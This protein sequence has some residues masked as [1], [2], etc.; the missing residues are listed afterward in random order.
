MRMSL[1]AGQPSRRDLFKSGALL[2]GV[3]LLGAPGSAAAAVRPPATVR[4]RLWL[5]GHAAGSHNGEYGL[6][7]ASQITP[8]EAAYY[9]SIPNM[10]LVRYKGKPEAPFDQYAIPFRSL[11]EVVWSVVGAGGATEAAERE[12]VLRM[13][14][15]SPNFTGVD[16]DD[17]F[18]GKKDG[19]VAALTVPELEQLQ[20]RLKGGR[21]KL[22]LWVTLYT[23]QLDDP[24]QDHLKYCDVVTLWTWKAADLGQLEANFEKTAKLAP[25]S[26]K[27]LGC[28]MWDYG[29]HK[30]MPIAAMEQQCEQG[31]KWLEEGKIDGIIFLAS[32]ICDLGLETVEWSRQ[33]IRKVGGRRL[34]K[35]A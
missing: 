35:Q 16:M 30:P 6:P 32:C 21:K 18:T 12:M 27:V 7:A 25:A 4:D 9:L 1:K 2:G 13:A 28:Y 11:R 14:E 23:H 20:K 33:W 19:K 24:I 22:N 15:Q 31:L 17:F 8:V 29:T 26:R 34:S 10:I 3:P 5:W